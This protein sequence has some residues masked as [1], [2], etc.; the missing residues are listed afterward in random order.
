MSPDC[1]PLSTPRASPGRAPGPAPERSQAPQQPNG[2]GRSLAWGAWERER[3]RRRRS[4]P[5]L[6]AAPTPPRSQPNADLHGSCWEH[7]NA[8]P[9][10]C[11]AQPSAHL[12]ASAPHIWLPALQLPAQAQRAPAGTGDR[13]AKPSLRTWSGSIRTGHQ[14]APWSN[15][16]VLQPASEGAAAAASARTLLRSTRQL[17]RARSPKPL[18]SR[19]RTTQVPFSSS[20]GASSTFP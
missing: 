13:R 9:G 18:P 5:A 3:Q 2:R 17:G 11:S 4:L 15:A 12:A 6:P 19:G 7:G 16:A 8:A 14:R 1:L 20:P 10:T